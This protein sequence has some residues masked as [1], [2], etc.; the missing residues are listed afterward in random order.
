MSF[1]P[2]QNEWEMNVQ[3]LNPFFFLENPLEKISWKLEWDFL[4]KQTTSKREK[5]WRAHS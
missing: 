3:R 4:G 1:H 2:N 5:E